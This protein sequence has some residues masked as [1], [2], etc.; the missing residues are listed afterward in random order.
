MNRENINRAGSENT[1]ILLQRCRSGD[2]AAYDA[3]FQAVYQDLRQRARAYLA[4]HRRATMSTTLLVHETYLKLAGADLAPRDRQHFYA[5]AARAMRQVLVD[6][7]RRRQAKCRGGDRSRV[8]LDTRVLG[9]ED[10]TGSLLDIDQALTRLGEED[11]RL[12]QVV[13]L[14]FFVGLG[15]A[16]VAELLGI[17]ERTVMRDWRAARAMLRMML[18]PGDEVFE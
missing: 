2:D 6:A 18:E 13:E 15:Y 9:V 5:L 8:P 16:E 17:S 10:R 7:V 3:L 1:A 14:H 12:A 4:G 11:R